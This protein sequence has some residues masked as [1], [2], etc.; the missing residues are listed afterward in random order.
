V[1]E[2]EL[3]SRLTTAEQERASCVQR[4]AAAMEREGQWRYLLAE[5][6]KAARGERPYDDELNLQV[7]RMLRGLKP[8][9]DS[10]A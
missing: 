8:L 1:N 9:G 6:A 3:R 4:L 10:A 7:E 5:T 2:R